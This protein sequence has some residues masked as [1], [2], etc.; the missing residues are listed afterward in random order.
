[1]ALPFFIFVE[2]STSGEKSKVVSTPGIASIGVLPKG[3]AEVKTKAR[4]NWHIV[5]QRERRNGRLSG[6]QNA[7]QFLYLCTILNKKVHF[8][9]LMHPTGTRFGPG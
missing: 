4:M 9:A 6:T 3:S 1:V 8:A 5:F 7:V 2:G